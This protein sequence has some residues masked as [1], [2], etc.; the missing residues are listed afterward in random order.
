MKVDCNN[1]HP[2][3][4]RIIVH[5]NNV[6]DDDDDDDKHMKETINLFKLNSITKSNKFQSIAKSDLPNLGNGNH[7]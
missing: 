7:L 4:S 5:K 6:D 1:Y 2:K 3:L